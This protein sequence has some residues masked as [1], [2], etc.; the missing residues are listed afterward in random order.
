MIEN[1]CVWESAKFVLREENLKFGINVRI[2]RERSE[3]KK[4]FGP[5][6][7]AKRAKNFFGGGSTQFRGGGGGGVVVRLG[8]GPRSGRGGGGSSAEPAETLTT[9]CEILAW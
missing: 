4:F 7:R 5:F 1:H 9:E 3:R 8:G 2:S 6:S